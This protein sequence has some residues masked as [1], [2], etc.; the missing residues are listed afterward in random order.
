[1]QVGIAYYQI[2]R[3]NHRGAL[4]MLLRSVQW[5][6]ILPDACQGIDVR[7]LREDSQ[8]VRAALEA[9]NPLEIGSFDRALLKP[10]RIIEPKAD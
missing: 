5:L 8:R 6:A 4:K 10:L 9:L 1:L 7:Q 2:E 3:G